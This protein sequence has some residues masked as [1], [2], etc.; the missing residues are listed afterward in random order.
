MK[1]SA[2]DALLGKNGAREHTIDCIAHI[3]ELNCQ[4]LKA[5]GHTVPRGQFIPLHG[6]G[7]GA[8]GV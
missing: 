3:K 7:L 6:S 1:R 8:S 4:A 2:E 5:N